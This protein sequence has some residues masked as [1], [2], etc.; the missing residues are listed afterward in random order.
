MYTKISNSEIIIYDGE[1]KELIGTAKFDLSPSAEDNL[2]QLV[3]YNITPSSLLL[4]NLN[5]YEIS[6]S[7]A[8]P[9]PYYRYMREGKIRATYTDLYTKDLVTLEIV[10][11]YNVR[12]NSANPRNLHFYDSV[13][14]DDIEVVAVIEV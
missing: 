11:K 10:L 4:L 12:V 7:Y 9:A 13:N 1:T 5:L 6:E 3:N 2:L 8:R 14:F